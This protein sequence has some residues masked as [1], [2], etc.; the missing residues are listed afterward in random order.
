MKYG[1]T[2][3]EKIGRTVKIKTHKTN[4]KEQY[5]KILTQQN[6]NKGKSKQKIKQMKPNIRKPKKT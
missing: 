2:D 4:R 5:R 1:E 6:K 3:A